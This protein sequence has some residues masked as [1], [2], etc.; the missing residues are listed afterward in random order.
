MTTIHT[1]Y[2]VGTIVEVDRVGIGAI[3]ETSYKVAGHGFEVWIPEREICKVAEGHYGEGDPLFST[4]AIPLAESEYAG[5]HTPGTPG[6]N[7]IPDGGHSGSDAWGI[8]GAKSFDFEPTN[9]TWDNHTTLPYN[10]SPQYPVEMFDHEQTQS[11]DHEIDHDDRVH[12]SDSRSGQ[13]REDV[14]NGPGPD[15]QL[16]AGQRLAWTPPEHPQHDPDFDEFEEYG[17]GQ[18]DEPDSAYDPTLRGAPMNGHQPAPE[19]IAAWEQ[20]Q[21]ATSQGPEADFFSPEHGAYPGD[22]FH[23]DPHGQVQIPGMGVHDPSHPDHLPGAGHLGSWQPPAGLSSKYAS[24]DFDASDHFNDPIIRFKD[25]PYREIHRTGSIN[26]SAGLDHETGEHMD[27]CRADKSYRTAAWNDVR[28]KAYRLKREGAVTVKAMDPSAIYASVEGDN[29]TYDVMILRGSAYSGLAPVKKQ[30]IANW[31]CSCD[32]GK[33]AFKRQLTYVG[34]LCSHGYATYLTQQ[35][36]YMKDK[37]EKNKRQQKAAGLDEFKTWVKNENGDHF[38]QDAADTFLALPDSE[39]TRDDAEKILDYVNTHH[40]EH[41]ERDY[42]EKGYHYDVNDDGM[43]GVLSLQPGKLSP[44]LYVVPEGEDSK[45]VSVEKDERKTTGPGQIQASSDHHPAFAWHDDKQPDYPEQG[46]VHFSSLYLRSDEAN[47]ERLRQVSKEPYEPRRMEEHN[48]EV[49]E[50]VSDLRERGY[51][52]S[53]MVAKRAMWKKADDSDSGMDQAMGLNTPFTNFF[54][55]QAKGMDIPGLSGAMDAAS[56]SSPGPSGH[57]TGFANPIQQAQGAPNTGFAN[58]INQ[59]KGAVPGGGGG[60]GHTDS[61]MGLTP[62]EAHGVGNGLS[63]QAI[64]NTQ[65]GAG[66]GAGAGGAAGSGGGYGGAGFQSGGDWK[67]SQETDALKPGSS[68][69]VK[70]GDTWNAIN[71]RAQGGGATGIGGAPGGNN[72][73]IHPGDQIAV[74]GPGQAGGKPSNT[75]FANPINQAQGAPAPAAPAAPAA[76]GP[77]AAPSA[78]AAAGPAS[79]VPGAAP[80]GVAGITEAHPGPGAGAPA[81]P[82]GPGGAGNATKAAPTGVPGIRGGSA[83]RFAELYFTAD[84]GSDDSSDPNKKNQSAT[85]ISTTPQGAGGSYKPVMNPGQTV[86]GPR[87]SQASPA[88][89]AQAGAAPGPQQQGKSPGGAAGGGSQYGNPAG[90]MQGPGGGGGAGPMGGGGLQQALQMAAP[91]MSGVAGAIPGMISG[92]GHGGIMNGLAGMAGGLGGLIPHLGAQEFAS[93]YFQADGAFGT[94]GGP[95]WMDHSFAGSGPDRQ[96]YSTT[97]EYYVDEHETANRDDTWV[98]DLDGDVTKYQERPKQ[99]KSVVRHQERYADFGG[100]PSG[101][102]GGFNAAPPTSGGG[103]LS[104]SGSGM[105][106]GHS[107]TEPVSEGAQ[108]AGAMIAHA[109]ISKSA[110][111]FWADV[112]I[113]ALAPGESGYFNPRN[114]TPNTTE[115]V[116]TPGKKKGPGKPGSPNGPN[117]GDADGAENEAAEDLD[118]GSAAAGLMEANHHNYTPYDGGDVVRRFQASGGGCIGFEASNSGGGYSDD[119][120]AQQAQRMLRTAGRHY[121]PMEEAELEGEFH[122]RGARNLSDLQLDGTHYLDD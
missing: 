25:D 73:M 55:D 113:E 97:S 98:T 5:H 27:L 71:T 35:S 84:D 52:V 70:P 87:P 116:N 51:D 49:S 106:M 119:G 74:N 39:A 102:S 83:Q 107:V 60:A 4:M 40:T 9:H 50:L 59:A 31:Q 44:H 81:P 17:H 53:P 6:H 47:L 94:P 12:S 18:D 103:S 64:Q 92:I 24:I 88:S 89:G 100:G 37:H 105:G 111:D 48:H 58:P 90:G 42:N 79:H 19:E 78:P 23:G 38:D 108:D 21:R 86:N 85:P 36:A 95:D 56:P 61:I 41:P 75:G 2:G 14:Y 22:Q 96:N 77:K 63:N 54:R 115:K 76:A 1:A 104:T 33:W 26:L 109:N 11:P 93:R 16:F 114:P 20:H 72:D 117:A 15:P 3:R 67:P 69:T 30:A 65:G 80:Q 7:P 46:I 122:P 120:I 121:S 118:P 82:P 28:D 45:F 91:L 57:N 34:R 101:Y 32:W 43:G 112:E 68:Y 29:G 62:G 13:D 10:W 66:V 110:R 99:A 8:T